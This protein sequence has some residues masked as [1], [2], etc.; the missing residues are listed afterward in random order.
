MAQKLLATR[1]EYA[2]PPCVKC[3]SSTNLSS[4]EACLIAIRDLLHKGSFD[5]QSATRVSGPSNT[6]G[7][8]KRPLN[9]ERKRIGGQ[10]VVF[11]LQGIAASQPRV[12]SQ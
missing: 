8:V 10:P 11:P 5:Q 3:I 6:Q 12:V 4:E 7:E 9:N 1:S 2:R